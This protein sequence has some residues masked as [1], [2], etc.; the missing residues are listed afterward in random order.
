MQLKF[1]PDKRN[2]ELGGG[3]FPRI[4]PN[5]DI[6]QCHDKDGN[7]TVDVVC[8]FDKPLPIQDH[9]ID[10]LFS[11][12]ALEHVSWRN[13]FQI[14]REIRRIM[15]PGGRIALVLPNTEAQFRWA[16]GL[17]QGD[18]QNIPKISQC[19]FG[20]QDYPENTHKVYLTPHLIQ[21]AL[22]SLTFVN[23]QIHP[24]GE[25]ETDMLVIAETEPVDSPPTEEEKQILPKIEEM[26][27]E[28]KFDRDYFNGGGKVGGYARE[29]YWDYPIHE[30]TAREVMKRQPESVLELGCARG[31]LVK[32]FQSHGI[33]ARGIE[34]SRHCYYTRAC[35]GIVWGDLL[36][37]DTWKEFGDGEFDLIFS[38]AVLEHVPA[39]RLGW[40]CEQM[41]RVSKRGLHG[42]DLGEKDD[43]FDKTHCT[44]EPLS[45]WQEILPAGH[46]PV[47]KEELEAG[48]IPLDYLEGDGKVKINLGSFTTMFMNGWMNVDV[49]DLSE[50]ASHYGYR[51]THQDLLNGIPWSTESVDCLYSSHV[52]EHLTYGQGRKF[53]RECRR[54]LKPSGAFRLLVPSLDVLSRAYVDRTIGEYDALSTT[55]ASAASAAQK[56][57]ELLMANHQSCWDWTLLQSEMQEAGFHISRAD[58]GSVS[59]VTAEHKIWGE[60]IE[61]NRKQILTETFDA[62]PTLSLIVEGWIAS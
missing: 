30:R 42:I 12:F 22:I 27:P 54:V 36:S 53:L 11:H 58:F 62:F 3:E 55:C 9:S 43:G 16:G 35:D 50:W 41:Q 47:D 17:D 31:Y 44:L 29:G 23:V 4:R 52:L 10:G 34:V 21:S 8:D 32:R 61:K 5:Y 15:A 57:W 14:L 49:V 20:D 37:E 1:D 13:F 40:L 45:F 39:E 38:Q 51:F 46:E 26:T 2:I 19:I 24:Y 60:Q 33:K 48:S 28:E 25:L 56:Y 59:N 6:R 18:P 7:P